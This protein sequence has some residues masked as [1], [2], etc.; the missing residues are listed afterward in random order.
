MNGT[1]TGKDRDEQDPGSRCG[2]DR[3]RDA[4]AAM[5]DPTKRCRTDPRMR[6]SPPPCL[7]VRRCWLAAASHS[8][9]ARRRHAPHSG[10]SWAA[11]TWHEMRSPV[12][13]VADSCTRHQG[14]SEHHGD[15]IRADARSFPTGCWH[16]LSAGPRCRVQHQR[17][18]RVLEEVHDQRARSWMVCTSQRM[19]TN[20]C[21]S[22]KVAER[23]RGLGA[24]LN[25][26]DNRLGTGQ[27]LVVAGAQ[28]ETSAARSALRYRGLCG[29]PVFLADG[30]SRCCRIKS[31]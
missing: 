6:L 5:K 22:G 27:G 13:D 17:D 7:L 19:R 11:G 28:T 8:A 12:P 23:G 29:A 3:R 21:E 4:R 18:V 10:Q 26:T 15:L 31:P 16:E 30:G 9:G 20:W 2:R 14:R 25:G 1:T 24:R